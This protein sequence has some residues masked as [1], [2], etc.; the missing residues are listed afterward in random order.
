MDL[1]D[2]LVFIGIL[3]IH[4][5]LTRLL[6]RAGRVSMS[7]ATMEAEALGLLLPLL[8]KISADSSSWGNNHARICKASRE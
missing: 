3:R 4:L 7:E 1:L 5:K 2:T 8:E 6:C